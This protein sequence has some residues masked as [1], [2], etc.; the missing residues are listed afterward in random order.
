VNNATG[1][2][3]PDL[4][5]GFILNDTELDCINSWDAYFRT[6]QR[7]VVLKRT[8][9][10]QD[11]TSAT[12]RGDSQSVVMMNGL[13]S[14]KSGAQPAARTGTMSGTIT[15][16]DLPVNRLQDKLKRTAGAERVED[17]NA[18]HCS[19]GKRSSAHGF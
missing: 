17:C 6:V 11:L 5:T 13:K 8:E 16:L 14:V 2:R 4:R 7:A 19:L 15:N 18:I 10:R 12:P 1:P 9:A 3:V